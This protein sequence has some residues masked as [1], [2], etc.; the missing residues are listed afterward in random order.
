[1]NDH[2][3]LLNPLLTGLS[4]DDRKDVLQMIERASS[5]Q[6]D[7][8]RNPRRRVRPDQESVPRQ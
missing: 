7:R 1:L 3:E 2:A 8:V 5:E 4:P 6:L